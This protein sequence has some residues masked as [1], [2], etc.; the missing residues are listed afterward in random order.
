MAA[1]QDEMRSSADTRTATAYKALGALAVPPSIAAVSSASF[2][3]SRANDC[4]CADA[5][6]RSPP[7]SLPALP[8]RPSL[9]W[10]VH[11]F[12]DWPPRTMES[13]EPSGALMSMSQ[14][15]DASGNCVPD[16]AARRRSADICSWSACD[17][18]CSWLICT[19]TVT[20]QE[21]NP[22]RN[23]IAEISGSI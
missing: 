20:N 17:H 11:P 9:E 12:A 13:F 23:I 14:T 3:V 2:C 19:A 18:D 1:F 21:T 15:V 5:L 6:S 16:A 4:A 10:G 7:F 22:H 8:V